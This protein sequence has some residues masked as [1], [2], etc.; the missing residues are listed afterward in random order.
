MQ[1]IPYFTLFLK[2]SQSMNEATVRQDAAKT[3]PTGSEP[4]MLRRRIGSTTFLVSVRFSEQAAET[5]EDTVLRLIER[6]VNQV[7]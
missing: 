5:P 4:I 1:R 3:S 7:A 2:R 6:E